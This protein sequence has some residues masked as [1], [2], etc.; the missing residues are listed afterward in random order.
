M[1]H[2]PPR[3]P[4]WKGLI[5]WTPFSNRSTLFLSCSPK[6]SGGGL[7]RPHGSR[8]VHHHNNLVP[9]FNQHHLTRQKSAS[10]PVVHRQRTIIK[11]ICTPERKPTSYSCYSRRSSITTSSGS[12][13]P[14]LGRRDWNRNLGTGGDVDQS[15]GGYL[16]RNYTLTFSGMLGR[17]LIYR[18]QI[19]QRFW[20]LP[21]RRRSLQTARVLVDSCCMRRGAVSV[22]GSQVPLPPVLSL[23]ALRVSFSKKSRRAKWK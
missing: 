23:L 7:S 5:K 19:D 8:I 3:P 12:P 2:F 4:R 16:L 18:C 10:L 15:S 14:S 11:T 22:P 20:F 13:A 6:P 21:Q 9:C 1:N 17:L